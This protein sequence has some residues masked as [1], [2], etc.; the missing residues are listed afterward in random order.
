M[1]SNRFVPPWNTVISSMNQWTAAMLDAP[2][3]EF[4]PFVRHVH[5][6]SLSAYRH[7]MY[8]V[9]ENDLLRD[10]VRAGRE[11]YEATCAYNYIGGATAPAAGRGADAEPVSEPEFVWEAPFSRIGHPCYLRA[12]GIGGHTLELRLRTL[13]LAKPLTG[14]LLADVLSRLTDAVPR[15]V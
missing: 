12:A 11:A 2:D 13:G 3:G 7:G 5:A 14:E 8:D 10:K 4:E 9:D 15:G 1:S 6:R